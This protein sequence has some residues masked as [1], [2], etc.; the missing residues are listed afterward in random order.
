MSE[1]TRRP[2]V[3]AVNRNVRKMAMSGATPR[4]IL[5]VMIVLTILILTSP[6]RTVQLQAR[7]LSAEV[8]LTAEPLSWNVTNATV[9]VPA[10]SEQ[11]LF[12]D[13][14]PPCGAGQVFETTLL[15]PILWSSGQRLSLDWTQAHL[16]VRL[17]NDGNRWPAG[18]ILSLDHEDATRNGALALSGFLSLGE[19]MSPGSTGYVLEG[20]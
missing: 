4:V 17:L 12:A 19:E 8:E 20:T 11:D 9:C 16:R 10:T 13:P 18:T 7:T 3:A 5:A 6:L 2:L 15:E 14:K 1:E